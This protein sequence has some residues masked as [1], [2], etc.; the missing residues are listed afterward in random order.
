MYALLLLLALSLAVTE[1]D[2]VITNLNSAKGA[3][4]CARICAGTTGK[5]TTSW[6]GSGGPYFYVS[7]R[8]DMSG[9]GFVGTPVITALIDGN[10]NLWQATTSGVSSLLSFCYEE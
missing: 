2:L 4:P 3:D 10:S 7:T 9:C 6:F 5:G 1:A 8:V